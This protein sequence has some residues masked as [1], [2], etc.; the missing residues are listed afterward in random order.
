MKKLLFIMLSLCTVLSL[1]VSATEVYQYTYD[2]IGVTIQFDENSHFSSDERKYIADFLAYGNTKD[3]DTSTY[4]WCWL[5]GHD[6]Q[7]D[8]VVSVHHRVSQTVPR[9]EETT[10]EVETCSKCD[11]LEYTALSAV[12]IDCCPEE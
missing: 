3:S 5:T 8:Y 7:Y 4:A 11:H 6:Y 9:C 12:Y 10:Y 2:D 1:C